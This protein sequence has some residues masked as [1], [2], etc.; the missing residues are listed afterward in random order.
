MSHGELPADFTGAVRLFPLP[1][2]VLFPHMILPLHIY[3]PRYCDMLADAL[4]TDQLITLALLQ[5]GWEPKYEA[6]P[7]LFDVVCVGEIVAHETQPNK[8]HNI[9]LR[10]MRRAKI[11]HELP[12][13]LAYRQAKVE[14]LE[15]TQSAL[16]DASRG[17]KQ[18]KILDLFR[19]FL[20]E[21]EI[22]EQQIDQLLSRPI[23]LSLLTD[24]VAFT[25]SFPLDVKQQL[26]IETNCDI[27]ADM[28]IKLLQQKWQTQ[29]DQA[30][31]DGYSFPPPFSEN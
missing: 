4:A 18:T 31:S 28:L 29:L 24:I 14:L 27:R 23:D 6:R 12:S 21:S 15:E 13:E 16:S 10:G 25:A 26:L 8:R 9:L 5:P 2:V 17:S 30:S 3:E 7:P 22:W 1:N 20:P 19:N 11:V